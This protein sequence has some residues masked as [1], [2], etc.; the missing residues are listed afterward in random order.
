MLVLL[1][2]E[3]QNVFRHVFRY[4][5]IFTCLWSFF[6]VDFLVNYGID[7]FCFISSVMNLHMLKKKI[8]SGVQ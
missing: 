1:L 7:L 4:I 5:W 8:M 3:K 2:L 6:V